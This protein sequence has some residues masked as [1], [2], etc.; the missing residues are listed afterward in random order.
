MLPSASELETADLVDPQ[1]DWDGFVTLPEN[2][3]AVRAARRLANGL[4]RLTG[5]RGPNPL[6]LHGLPGTGKSRLAQ[7]LVRAV[8]ADS[9]RTALVVT[10]R[11]A[12]TEPDDLLDSDLLI[13]EDLHHLPAKA[14]GHVCRLLDARSQ[15]RRPT[16]VTATAGP[17]NLTRL[18]RRLTSRLAAGLVVGLEPVTLAGRR[19]IIERM[20]TIRNIHLT[21][22]AVV[23]LAAHTPGGGVRPLLG[24]LEQLATLAVSRT[25]PVD[26]ATAA[27]LLSPDS[28]EHADPVDRII[29]RVAMVFSVSPKDV[30]GPR[31]L[32]TVTAARRVAM[33]LARTL[34]GA[35]LPAIG[36]QFGG[37]DH[38]TVLHA[39]RTVEAELPTDAKLTRIVR[40]L[41][42]ELG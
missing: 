29:A 40:E 27:R 31:R 23:W 17:A 42:A 21:A 1:A 39:C 25:E 36:R 41:Q 8:V 19:V 6:V 5:Y 9:G 22:D 35:S 3:S 10:A 30:T 14:A 4:T 37:R 13:V 24:R 11:D 12:A 15:R 38:T 20:A 34:T 7:T 33:Y 16:V 28:P 18:P 2:A 32:R 26:A